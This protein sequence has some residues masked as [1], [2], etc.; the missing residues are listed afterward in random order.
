MFPTIVTALLTGFST[1]ALVVAVMVLRRADKIRVPRKRL[2][3]VELAQIDLDER[4]EALRASFK[5][6]NARIGMRE[7]RAKLAEEPEAPPESGSDD[8][9]QQPNE[10]PSEWKARMRQLI[11]SGRLSHGR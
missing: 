8:L 6:L 3:A 2:D 1:V 4:F 11:H 7:A 9:K 10:S 5:R